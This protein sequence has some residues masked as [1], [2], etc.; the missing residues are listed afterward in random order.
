MLMTR[1]LLLFPVLAAMVSA[2]TQA[3]TPN[4][5]VAAACKSDVQRLC[6]GVQP[7]GGRI[8]ECLKA[9]VSE[10]S[11]GCLQAAKASHQGSAAGVAH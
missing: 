11:P 6:A 9:H 7:G 8:G 5:A 1:W 3:Q 4:P 2:P 10:V